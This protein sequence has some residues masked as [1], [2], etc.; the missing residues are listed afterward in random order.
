MLPGRTDTI[1]TCNTMIKDSNFFADDTLVIFPSTPNSLVAIQGNVNLHPYNDW[2]LNVKVYDG[3]GTNGTLLG[4]YTENTT[5]PAHISTDGPL[6]L[7]F[8]CH[9]YYDGGFQLYVSCLPDNGCHAS[10]RV[11]AHH[12]LDTSVSLNWLYLDEM[13][14]SFTVAYAPVDF[15]DTSDT[16][17]YQ[18]VSGI[19]DTVFV[20]G[21]LLTG[22]HYMVAVRAE[23]G[24]GQYSRW[25]LSN[26]FYT[27]CMAITR[28]NL[29][30]T[31]DFSSWGG[32]SFQ[33]LNG[34][35]AP[36]WYFNST[37]YAN[38]AYVY[39]NSPNNT[40][41]NHYVT[42]K[43]YGNGYSF[44]VLPLFADSVAD[45]TVS[46]AAQNDYTGYYD[47]YVE[48]VE[49]GV[50]D[51]PRDFSTYTP[52]S[53][54]SLVGDSVHYF[55]KHLDSYTGS[56]RYIAIVAPL[57][58][59]YHSGY[60]LNVAQIQVTMDLPCMPPLNI[61]V[62]SVSQYEATLTVVDTTQPANR[63]FVYGTSPSFSQ[64]DSTFTTDI[65]PVTISGLQ[66]GKRYY[67]WVRNNNTIDRVN[68]SSPWTGPVSFETA[69]DPQPV[70]YQATAFSNDS[71]L[72]TVEIA[73]QSGSADTS[74]SN[75]F[76][77]G[78]RLVFTATPIG[79]DS[80][81]LYWNDGDT[82]NPRILTLTQD[83]SLTAFF[84]VD[85][86]T[87]G[88]VSPQFTF[89]LAPNPASTEVKLTAM[90]NILS[91]ECYDLQGRCVASLKPSAPQCSLEVADWPRGIYMIKVYS[92]NA[93][94]V[95]K[96][97]VK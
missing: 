79:S 86:T 73:V 55:T 64:C 56:G 10:P 81:F 47:Q 60:G 29:P 92:G 22:T 31:E 15:F 53:R 87:E 82:T 61:N 76:S 23:C 51:D 37:G 83:T 59:D 2:I 48:V 30:F 71:S 12:P 57:M 18:V 25:T 97:I 75:M 72:G 27:S 94:A 35:I 17:T 40:D 5:M 84:A 39:H 4:T 96:L 45:L 24:D 93:V 62:D 41:L 91:V 14:A 9:D 95:R 52:I 70:Y 16:S 49:I 80:R 58:S 54:D 36:C 26:D 63:T 44:L 13:P 46:Y 89:K 11:V 68:Y 42:M 85:T 28:D 78:S 38:T 33:T 65:N 32:A 88:I 66:P 74:N 77:E 6:T 3:V 8:S 7:V 20:L 43:H 21:G 90:Q 67:V 19:T 34:A 50:L 69:A 1:V